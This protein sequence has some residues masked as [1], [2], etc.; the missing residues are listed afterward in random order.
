VARALRSQVVNDRIIAASAPRILPPLT[1]VNRPFWT[2]GA[3]GELMIQRCTACARWIHPPTDRCAE[4]GGELEFEPVSG[5][6]TLFTFTENFQQ[7]HPDVT[8]P[9]VVGIVELDEQDDL[10]LPTN[11]VNADESTLDCGM[12]VR[13]LFEQHGEVFV[14]V[15]EPTPITK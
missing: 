10:R 13:V 8:P 5:T 15:F 3:R 2:G 9:Y 7:F 4:C 1:D 14:P 6:G 11:I 12:A